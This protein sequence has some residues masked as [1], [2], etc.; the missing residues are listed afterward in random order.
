MKVTKTFIARLR[1]KIIII[2]HHKISQ[3]NKFR[4]RNPYL[5]PQW[6]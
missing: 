6:L 4:P 2:L 5:G 1:F 3:A